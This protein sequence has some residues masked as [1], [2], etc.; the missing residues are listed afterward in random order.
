M[1]FASYLMENVG[2]DVEQKLTK[3]IING[4]SKGENGVVKECFRYVNERIS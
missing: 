4:E 2:S 1:N 3:S